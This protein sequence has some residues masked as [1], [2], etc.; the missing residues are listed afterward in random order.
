MQ[1]TKGSN[2]QICEGTLCAYPFSRSQGSIWE[3]IILM[4]RARFFRH[5]NLHLPLAGTA[6]RNSFPFGPT[7]TTGPLYESLPKGMSWF[8]FPP[9]V[10]CFIYPISGHPWTNGSVRT[11]LWVYPLF[12]NNKGIFQSSTEE[13]LPKYVIETA[14]ILKQGPLSQQ[15]IIQDLRDRGLIF[16]DGTYLDYLER[17]DSSKTVSSN[18]S[19]FA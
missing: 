7:C 17:W 6:H 12:H 10:R 2:K 3:G 15:L 13:N 4:K 9:S 18:S 14:S 1:G 5:N 16:V 8:S 19:F 11:R